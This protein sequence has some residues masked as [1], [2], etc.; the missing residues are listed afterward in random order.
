VQSAP[1]IPRGAARYWDYFNAESF[2]TFVRN[3][4]DRVYSEYVHYVNHRGWTQGFEKFVRTSHCCNRLGMLL[5]DVDLDS[6]GFIGFMEELEQSLNALSAFL[7]TELTAHSLNRGDYRS[8]DPDILSKDA[9]RD[10]VRE[11]SREDIEIYERLRKQRGGVFIRPD[12]GKGVTAGYAGAV[13]CSEGVATGWLCN[14]MEEFIAEVEVAQDGVV[15]T[16]A[17]ADRYRPNLKKK[18]VSRSGVCGFRIDLRPH[19]SAGSRHA[20]SFKAAGS[21]YE[22]SGSPLRFDV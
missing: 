5:A 3:P 19:V 4:V 17:K 16:R 12:I 11:L 21:D 13:R 8:I 1:E 14:T 7:E 18:G 22:L 2:I 15:L 9:H 10:M 20:V 6:F